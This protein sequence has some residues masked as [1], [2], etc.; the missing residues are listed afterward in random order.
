MSEHDEVVV[1]MSEGKS[2]SC[3]SCGAVEDDD[4]KLVPC[5]GCDLVRY[6]SE[7]CRELHRPAHAGKCRKREAELRDELLFK[8]P[9]RS[10][11]LPNLQFASD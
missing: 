5:N 1:D 2:F 6:C 11:G 8:Q 10:W 7:A 9:E 3:A 4:I